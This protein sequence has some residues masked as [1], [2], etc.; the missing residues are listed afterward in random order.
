MMKWKKKGSK[1]PICGNPVMF[2]VDKVQCGANSDHV[3][4]Y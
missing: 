1:C 4:K 2:G 3:W